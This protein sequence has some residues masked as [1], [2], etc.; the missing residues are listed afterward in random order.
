M[1]PRTTSYVATLFYRTI[2]SRR[3][4]CHRHRCV[5]SRKLFIWFFLVESLKQL[6]NV[7]MLRNT[8]ET[9][10]NTRSPSRF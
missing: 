1:L 8:V 6:S 7:D 2:F 4:G 10:K 9:F 3:S 5:L